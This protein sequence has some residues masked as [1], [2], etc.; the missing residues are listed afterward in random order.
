MFPSLPH[1]VVSD[2]RLVARE[3]CMETFHVAIVGGGISGL[4][5]AYRL[6]QA[7]SSQRD[8]LRETLKVHGDCL[9]VVILE[10]NPVVLGGRIRS[11]DLPTPCGSVRAELGAMRIT[12]RHLLARHLLRDL[13]VQTIPFEGDRFSEHFF[14][15]GKHF[16]APDVE[17]DDPS[18]FPY[19]IEGPHEKRRTPG[20]LVE[21]AFERAL[22]ELSLDKYATAETLLVL[23]KLRS[24]AARGTLTHEEWLLIQKHGLLPSRVELKDIGV[25]NLL[26]HYLSPEAASFV[27]G[28]FGYESVIGNWNVSDAIPW[29]I[30]DF[31]PG[32]GYESIV[33]S[34]SEVVDRVTEKV[35]QKT[36]D[37]FR[38]TIFKNAQVTG[39]ARPDD[40]SYRLTIASKEKQY[41]HHAPEGVIAGAVFLALPRRPLENLKIAWLDEPE[42]DKPELDKEA[43]KKRREW[44]ELLASVRGHRLAKV[45]QAYRHPWWRESVASRG[46]ASRTFTDLPLR[47]VYY[48]DREW[49]AERGRYRNDDGRI[50][51][52]KTSEI[53]GM[54]VAYLDGHYTSFW[55]FIT[56]V[57]RMHDLHGGEVVDKN[58]AIRRELEKRKSFGSRICAWQEPRDLETLFGDVVACAT[59]RDRALYLYYF[60]Y[61]LYDRAA[62]K[63]KHSL[64]W[65]HRPAPGYAGA[66]VL[67]PV[68]GAYT[69]WDDFSDDSVIGAGWHTWESGV[70]SA[71]VIRDLICPFRNHKVYVCGE[72]YSSEQGWI[73]GALKSVELIM[74]HLGIL[75]PGESTD[76]KA[77][78]DVKDRSAGIRDHVGL[79]PRS[80]PP[81]TPPMSQHYPVKLGDGSVLVFLSGKIG[82]QASAPPAEKSFEREARQALQS[83]LD[84][85]DKAGG[86]PSDLVSVRAFLRTMDDY[87]NFNAIYKMMLE[88]AGVTPPVRT[89]IAVHD[90]PFGALV[91]VDGIAVVKNKAP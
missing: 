80:V 41:R 15:R 82:F 70:S 12:T 46:R 18:T 37:H 33:G 48:L 59:P 52:G 22:Q 19:S 16:D 50:D 56:A 17:R 44:K 49:L 51:D 63:M 62:A 61:G 47:Q 76:A 8:Q 55:R 73:E 74:D 9:N 6:R 83:L 64:E 31:S 11:A 24:V 85:I 1:C 35:T 5:A 53:G 78:E 89:A 69:F 58:E 67:D 66:K 27:D 34:L 29:F 86:A 25:W 45:V 68:A 75:L 23:E 28:G 88:Q 43:E 91:E 32:Q 21:Y 14:L 39:L 13:G 71:G 30:A 3:V 20:A 42:R 10:R 72:A 2:S 60:H 90:L 40:T 54:I 38:C 36:D 77:R 87:E 4:Y 65:L 26:H 57:Q 79:P 7:W 84:E 81:I